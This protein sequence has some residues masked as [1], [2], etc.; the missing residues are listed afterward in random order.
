MSEVDRRILQSLMPS[1]AAVDRAELSDLHMVVMRVLSLNLNQCLQ[2]RSCPV[3]ICDGQ[4]KTPFFYAAEMGDAAAVH[5][6]SS[7]PA[8]S[9]TFVNRESW[10]S[11]RF[12]LLWSS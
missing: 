2:L 6:P 1:D 3:N 5:T 8:R 4:S 10:P 9:P 11:D 7:R 12:T